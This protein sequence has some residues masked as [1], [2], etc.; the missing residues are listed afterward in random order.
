VGAVGAETVAAVKK[1]PLATLDPPFGLK[2][3]EYSDGVFALADED[4]TEV[5]TALVAVTV[6]VYEVPLESP[7][8]VHERVVVFMQPEGAVTEGEALT[9]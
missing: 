9:V 4:A 8:K 6:N 2:V 3:T 1:L 7:V 5:P